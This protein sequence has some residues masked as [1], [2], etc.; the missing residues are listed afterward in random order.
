[1]IVERP[2]K[3]ERIFILERMRAGNL[4][5][6]KSGVS[7]KASMRGKMNDEVERYA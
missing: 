7:I 1:L 2:G 6:K 3:R 5:S 4:Y